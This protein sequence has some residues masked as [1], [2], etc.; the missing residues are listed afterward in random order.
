MLRAE[1]IDWPMHRLY[2]SQQKLQSKGKG[3]ACLVIG[4]TL[5]AVL[6]QL[7]TEGPLF[8]QLSTLGEKQR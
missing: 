6:R 2:Y 1:D 3:N 4:P 7:P 5:E 8:A